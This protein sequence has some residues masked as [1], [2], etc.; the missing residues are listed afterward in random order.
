MQVFEKEFEERLEALQHHSSAAA[1]FLYTQLTISHV[2]SNDI[3]TSVEI[4]GH[5]AFWRGI[6]GSLQTAAFVSPRRIYDDDRNTHSATQLLNRATKLCGLFSK[7]S[8]GAREMRAGLS[9]DDAA[10]YAAQ[11]FIPRERDLQPLRTAY[12]ARQAILP[13]ASLP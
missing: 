5:E 1:V 12:A 9:A 10:D 4:Q 2:A 11:A 6:L 8:L 3:L 13:W 7:Q